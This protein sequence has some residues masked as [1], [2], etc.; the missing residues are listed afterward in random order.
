M[1]QRQTRTNYVV[2]PDEENKQEKIS[3]YVG[4]GTIL[5][6]FFTFPLGLLFLRCPVDR[7]EKEKIYVLNTSDNK[8]LV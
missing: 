8:E 3:Y 5:L 1:S 4:V 6:I 2:V 7:V